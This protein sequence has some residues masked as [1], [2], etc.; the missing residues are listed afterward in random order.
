V[1]DIEN[2]CYV[3]VSVCGWETWYLVPDVLPELADDTSYHIVIPVLDALTMSDEDILA[4][5]KECINQVEYA[6]AINVVNGMYSETSTLDNQACLNLLRAYGVDHPEIHEAIDFLT[7]RI[8]KDAA[9][10]PERIPVARLRSEMSNR[11][12]KFFIKVGRRDGFHCAKCQSTFD[13]QID[14]VRPVSLGGTND[15]DNLQLLC[16]PCNG[17]KG[18]TEVDYRTGVRYE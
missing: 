18:A 8:E 4:S 1:I 9:R 6:K 13:L 7:E 12:E 11:Y 15:L 5:V 14:H 10:Y 2:Q 16:G 3:P 17:S